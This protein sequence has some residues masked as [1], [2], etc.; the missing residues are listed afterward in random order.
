MARPPDYTHGF[1][2][3]IQIRIP[4]VPNRGR[5]ETE[6]T[7]CRKACR[8][9]FH[10]PRRVDRAVDV[11]VPLAASAVLD[12]NRCSGG[13]DRLLVHHQDAKLIIRIGVEGLGN[14]CELVWER[15]MDETHL[16]DR[17]VPR[18]DAVLAAAAR[19]VPIGP[20]RKMQN[21]HKLE[22][23]M[24][25][26]PKLPGSGL[27]TPA[28]VAQNSA[29]VGPDLVIDPVNGDLAAVRQDPLGSGVAERYPDTDDRVGVVAADHLDGGIALRGTVSGSL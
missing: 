17:R 10:D 19:G 9:D 29:I 25:V 11:R 6:S 1:R 3:K 7:F 21:R 5:S 16:I 13:L 23:T 28:K 18:R 14:C 24:I 2:A 26:C 8:P 4:A 15:R 22:P 27:A 12:H 20:P